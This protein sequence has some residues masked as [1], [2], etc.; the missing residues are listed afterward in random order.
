MKSIYIKR[1]GAYLFDFVVVAFLVSIIT[2]GFIQ[3]TDVSKEMNELLNKVSNETI[4][5]EE[6]TKQAFKLNYDYQKNMIPTTIVNVTISIGY[7]IVFACLN[8][9]QTLGKKIFKIRVVD[10]DGNNPNILNMLGRSIFLYGIIAS[11]INIVGV[12]VFNVKLFNYVSSSASYIYYIFSIVCFLMVMY[13]KDGRGLHDMIGKTMV[14][15]EVR[16]NGKN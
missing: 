3:D 4:T 14:V 16:L 12:Y 13:R 8:K 15:E 10:K 1:L 5:K 2:I 6:Y 7:F 11:T 9:G